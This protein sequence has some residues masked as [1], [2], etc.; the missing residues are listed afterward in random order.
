MSAGALLTMEQFEQL[1]QEDG[2]RY[3][4]KDGRLI[5]RDESKT[6]LSKF[7]DERI[8]FRVGR[9]RACAYLTSHS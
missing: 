4:L 2:V 7:G 1:P 9:R 8:A 6:G 5:R 3:E